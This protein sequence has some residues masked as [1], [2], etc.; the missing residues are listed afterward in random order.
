M[1]PGAVEFRLLRY[2]VILAEELSFTRAAER[3]NTSQ[4]SLSRQILKLEQDIGVKLFHR[5]KRWVELTPAGQRFVAEAKK[6]LTHAE[7]S[8]ELA[9]RVSRDQQ[10]TFTIGYCEFIDLA[11]LSAVRRMKPPAHFV[12]RSAM[13]G[14][15]VSKL[16]R[17][18][19]EAAFMVL[20]VEEPDLIA[21]PLLREPLA[22]ALPNGHRLANKNEL[23]VSDL[24]GEVVIVSSKCFGPVFRSQLFGELERNRLDLLPNHEP[25]NP[26]EALHMVVERFGIALLPYS[27]VAMS[28]DIVMHPLKGLRTEIET[29]LIFHRENDS[30]ILSGYVEAVKRVRDAYLRQRGDRLRISA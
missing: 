21:E 8:V 7:R 25:A 11:L 18:E 6:A 26:H 19:W 14:D 27:T 20:P 5:S 29:G 10:E 9:S 13:Y 30:S 1:Y 23:T 15:I 24:R 16:L 4:P 2:V 22:A 17:H 12:Y 3:L 28:K